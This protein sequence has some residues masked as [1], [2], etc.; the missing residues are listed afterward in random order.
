M[1]RATTNEAPTA[2]SS[3]ALK[4]H[5]TRR[6]H[7]LAARIRQVDLRR[8]LM[9]GSTVGWPASAKTTVA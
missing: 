8:Q 7:A 3:N 1:E 2:A 4:T 5:H 9:A 6:R